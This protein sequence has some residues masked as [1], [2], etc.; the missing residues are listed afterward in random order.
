MA[1]SGLRS[2]IICVGF[3]SVC[4]VVSYPFYAYHK[5]PTSI[6]PVNCGGNS[7]VYEVMGIGHQLC[8]ED[9]IN[10]KKEN[11]TQFGKVGIYTHPLL[12]YILVHLQRLILDV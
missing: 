4:Y 1:G 10:T 7:T 2:V 9:Y 3:T 5:L 12:F 6:V 11:V 8:G